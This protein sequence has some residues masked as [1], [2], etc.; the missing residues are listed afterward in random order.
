MNDFTGFRIDQ[1]GCTGIN[2]NLWGFI[3]GFRFRF[4]R[5][6][7]IR[8]IS[9]CVRLCVIRL[10][11]NIIKNVKSVVVP[12]TGGG[13]GIQTA[14]AAGLVAGCPQRR[15]EVLSRLIEDDR[16]AIRGLLDMLEGQS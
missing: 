3:I 14:L 1:N 7:L 6:S 11:G 16:G 12:G 9:R 10:S 8:R 4:R 13:R 15:L 5:F 2:G